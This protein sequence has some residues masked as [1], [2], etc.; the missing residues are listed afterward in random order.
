[1]KKRLDFNLWYIN[2][3]NLW[4]DFVIL[5]RTFLEVVRHRNAC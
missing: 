3:W 4:L 2:N 1:M 5:V